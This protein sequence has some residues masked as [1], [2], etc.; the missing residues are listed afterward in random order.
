MGGAHGCPFGTSTVSW[1]EE[2]KLN[3]RATL[4]CEESYPQEE[5]CSPW[6]DSSLAVCAG[7]G[8]LLDSGTQP[9][10]RLTTVGEDIAV[11]V[12]SQRT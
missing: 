7:P 10:E 4:L 6:S 1:H 11:V 12:G 2:E 9:C 3:M 8:T 5:N